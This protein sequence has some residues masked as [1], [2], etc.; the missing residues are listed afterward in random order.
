MNR[1]TLPIAFFCTAMF[2]TATAAADP[3]P[4]QIAG[5][6][7]TDAVVAPVPRTAANP[8]SVKSPADSIAAV[9]ARRD[10]LRLRELAK[11]LQSKIDAASK[12]AAPA[13]QNLKQAQV[14]Q[15]AAAKSLV[16]STAALKQATDKKTAADKALVAARQTLD[17]ANRKAAETAKQAKAAAGKAATK[18][19]KSDAAAEKTLAELQQAVD[20]AKRKLAE[21]ETTLAAAAGKKQ[22]ETATVAATAAAQQVT[23]TTT[24]KQKS[25]ADK[26]AADKQVVA[27]TAALKPLAEAKT[28]AEKAAEPTIRRLTAAEERVILYEKAVPQADPKL[29]RLMETYKHSR[30]VLSCR[31]SPDGENLFF[32]AQ[33]N[34]LH[35]HDLITGATAELVGHR[36]WIRRFAFHPD[37]HRLLTG[38]YEGQLI[39]WNAQDEKP[40]PLKNVDAHKGFVRAV[41][42]SPDGRFVA[43]GGNDNMVRVWSADDGKMVA[44]LSGHARHV[45]NVAFH[46]N[47]QN[48]ISGD[49]M[50]VLKQWEV[51]SWKHVRDFDCSVLTKYDKTF[52][53][54][55]GGIR[56]LDFSPGGKS[57]VVSGISEVSNAFAGVGVPTAVLFDWETGKRLNVFKPAKKFRGACWGVRFHPSGDFIIGAGGG[58][59]G[60]MWFWKPGQDKSFFDY[61]LP[62]VAYDV[63]LHPD[64]LRLAVACYDKTVRIYNLGPKTESEQKAEAAAAKKK[65]KKK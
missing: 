8:I 44:E 31:I 33:D 29:V 49:L 9:F 56:G 54:D 1:N 63:A 19:P 62:N 36:S 57:L 46:P 14:A 5:T 15:A 37:G 3:P 35:R 30:P 65:K 12:Q 43:T 42:I 39:W 64:G 40:T 55:C 25:T 61:K 34:Q 22:F 53:A 52:R 13:E 18:P 24:R 11:P 59:G 47:G 23:E 26:T 21:A 16:V 4:K 50:G 38:A 60:S 20:R 58:S 7:S 48:L 6:V 17:N 41:A 32:G 10:A 28:A 51:G 2:A 45:Y 27:A